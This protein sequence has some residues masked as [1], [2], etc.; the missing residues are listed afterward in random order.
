MR[1]RFR[2][3]VVNGPNDTATMN[4]KPPLDPGLYVV[5]VPIGNARDITLRA[6]DILE[7]AN[8]IACEDTRITKRLLSLHGITAGRRLLS[9][10]DHN[11]R[12]RIPGLVK[13]IA[14]DGSIALASDAG[15]P[16][17]S[18]PGFRL[19]KAVQ[20]A[21]LPV[22][23]VPGASALTAALSIAGQPTSRVLFLGFLS[24]SRAARRAALE[25][26][27][28]ANA[29]LVIFERADRL[30]SL[31]EDLAKVGG[32]RETTILREMSKLHEE[33]VR[34][35]P[36]KLS[37]RY[38]ETPPKGEVVVVTAPPEKT[39]A[40]NDEDIEA[41]LLSALDVHGPSRAAALTA[42]ATGLPRAKLYKR[43]LALSAKIRSRPSPVAAANPG[44]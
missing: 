13:K 26:A 24:R 44:K 6:L 41:Q 38:A 37:S 3:M 33:S 7:A 34:G 8:T 4:G 30:S 32:V 12:M 35:D 40:A 31:L 27:S 29:S 39:L 5:A 25:T 20:A 23:A 2:R 1:A 15:T 18:D 14:R 19:V 42:T 21:N 43:A 17:V 11:A 10:N 28:N 16:L 9:Y 36:L 22:R